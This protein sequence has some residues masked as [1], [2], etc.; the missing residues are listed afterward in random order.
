M[1]VFFLKPLKSGKGSSERNKHGLI[2]LDELI[3][4]DKLE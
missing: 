3:S 2:F 4:E 1:L